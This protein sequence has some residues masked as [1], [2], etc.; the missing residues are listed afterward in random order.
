MQP[1]FLHPPVKH[2]S[3]MSVQMSDIVEC[4]VSNSVESDHLTEREPT[5]LWRG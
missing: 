2:V 4:A 3:G 1:W 5:D